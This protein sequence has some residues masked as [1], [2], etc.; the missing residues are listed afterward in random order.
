MSAALVV[1]AGL[2]ALALVV[3]GA[4]HATSPSTRTRHLPP[5]LSS[6][7]CPRHAQPLGADAVAT[8]ATVALHAES[9]HQLP[10][11]AA[12][13]RADTPFAGARGGEVRHYCGQRVWHRTVVVDITLRR[14]LPSASLSE[15]VSLVARTPRGYR[16]YAIAH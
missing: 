9:R 1:A 13:S 12:A 4:A 6:N 10:E 3:P 8:A 5:F 15:R 2:G 11:L 7:V 16:I 14:Y